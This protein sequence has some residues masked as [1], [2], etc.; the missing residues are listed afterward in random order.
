VKHQNIKVKEQNDDLDI[1]ESNKGVNIEG[2]VE[3]NIKL[4]NKNLEKYIEND[5]KILK[6]EEIVE[7]NKKVDLNNIEIIKNRINDTESV[8]KDIFVVNKTKKNRLKKKSY[9][10]F[11]LN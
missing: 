9:K 2:D 3:N 11:Y 10:R 8:N 6:N 1:K 4:E 7:N 5:N